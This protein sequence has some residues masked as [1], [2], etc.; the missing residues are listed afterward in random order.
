M[1]AAL[2]EEMG[3]K[4]LIVQGDKKEAS[5]S[6]RNLKWITLLAMLA[7]LAIVVSIDAVKDKL[8][9]NIVKQEV[10]TPVVGAMNNP[11]GDL[12]LYFADGEWGPLLQS[13]LTASGKETGES[14]IMEAT[15]SVDGK[16]LEWNKEVKP[17]VGVVNEGRGG[18]TASLTHYNSQV[19][20]CQVADSSKIVP[21]IESW[22][23]DR[24]QAIVLQSAITAYQ[25]KTGVLPDKAEQLA[26]PYP[27][28]LL[29]GVSP[30][31]Q[32]IFPQALEKL[33][34][35]KK[36][37]DGAGIKGPQETNNQLSKAPNV[38]NSSQAKAAA[39]PLEEPLRIIID[40]E[41]HRLA[42]VSGKYMLRSY[43]VGLGGEKTPEGDF[44]ISEKVRNPN[45]R[46]NGEF[47]SRGMTLSDTLYAIHGTNKPSSVGKDESHGCV[48]MQ[49]ED[50]E[51]LYDMVPAQ[52]KVTI[53]K[54][55]LPDFEN[56]GGNGAG[57]G[58]PSKSFKLPLQT[59]DSNP[60]KKYKWL[61]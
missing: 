8:P 34:G 44:I 39:E 24:E 40:T 19:C 43:P 41:K 54:G 27:D 57:R 59:N 4:T 22:M 49:Q 50:V 6:R 32:E 26:K 28:N 61:D 42:L 21:L 53:G 9:T 15:K 23:Q 13:V 37:V 30:A 29:P 16:W 3:K 17:V 31:M 45:G 14:V 35:N 2:K 58:N 60:N 52:T 25:Q 48:R 56:G 47:G 18:N 33:S 38:P 10:A 51:E 36:T 46:S 55:V 11:S 1:A 5:K 7:F 12:K 20:S